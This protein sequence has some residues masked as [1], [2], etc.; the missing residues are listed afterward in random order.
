MK[1]FLSLVLLSAVLLSSCTKED[2]K[3]KVIEATSIALAPKTMALQEGETGQLKVVISPENTKDKSVE[4]SVVNSDVA[5]VSVDGLVSAIKEGKT[6][7]VAITKNGKQAVCELTVSKKVIHVESITINPLVTI[8]ADQDKEFTLSVKVLPENATNK[9]I[10]WSLSEDDIIFLSEDEAIISGLKP[11]KVTITVTTEDKNLS[12]SCIVTVKPKYVKATEVIIPATETMEVG[13]TKTLTAI[14]LPDDATHK[15]LEWWI[16]D[17]SVATIDVNTGLI[18]ALKAGKVSV[19]AIQNKEMKIGVCELT[20]VEPKPVGTSFTD[21]RDGQVYKT[22]T[23][24]GVEWMAENLRYLPSVS[25]HSKVT[26]DEACCYVY[27]YDGEDVNEAK[28]SE[29]YKKSGVLY[30]WE[31]LK[32]IAPDGW[33]VSFDYDWVD[34]EMFLGLT[35]KEAY[36]EGWRGSIADRLKSGEYW[37]I[38]GTNETELSV[39]PGGSIKYG[40]PSHP[41]DFAGFWTNTEDMLKSKALYRGFKDTEKGVEALAVSKMFAYSVRCVRI[42]K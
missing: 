19:K 21:P 35:S 18:T 2:V 33:R 16:S 27:D 38:P 34:M 29:Q 31:A 32:T 4:Y 5:S 13:T 9:K 1:K 30:N 17:A 11:G 6:Q 41:N 10:S 25:K 42:K 24:N 26:R 7:I 22:V 37:T 8:T 28:K 36:A 39:I 14:V 3:E 20:V 23:I 40:F 15:E 12:A